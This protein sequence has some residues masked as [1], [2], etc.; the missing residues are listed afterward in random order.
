MIEELP[1]FHAAR[2]MI[3]FQ[4]FYIEYNLDKNGK[5]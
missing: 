5:K 4:Y 1:S 2:I 3:P